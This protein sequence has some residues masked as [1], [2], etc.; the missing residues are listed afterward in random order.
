MKTERWK[1]L[2]ELFHAATALAPKRRAAF[3][4][5]ACG[6]DDDL[7]RELDSLIEH[8]EQAKGLIETPAYEVAAELILK[9]DNGE[10]M[11]GRTLGSY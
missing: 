1:K 9:G 11:I 7:R 4:V 3:L 8:D 10:S 6:S 2:E 5:E